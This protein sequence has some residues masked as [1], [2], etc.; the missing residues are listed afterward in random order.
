VLDDFPKESQA[1]RECS[2]IEVLPHVGTGGEKLMDK[3]PVGSMYQ[4]RIES[5][6]E[7]TLGSLAEDFHEFFDLLDL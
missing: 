6:R 3:V 2:P 7:R 5:S 4:D 1:P